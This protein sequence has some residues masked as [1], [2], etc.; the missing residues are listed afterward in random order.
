MLVIEQYDRV[1]TGSALCLRQSFVTMTDDTKNGKAEAN[2]ESD[3]QRSSF[4]HL[5]GFG[6]FIPLVK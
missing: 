2:S 5:I 4:F 3:C 6:A 1:K